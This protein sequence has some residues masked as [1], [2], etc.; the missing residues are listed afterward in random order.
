VEGIPFRLAE[1]FVAHGTYRAHKA[2][3]AS[4]EPADFSQTQVLA[5]G[6]LYFINVDPAL[7]AN[8]Q[9]SFQQSANGTVEQITMNTVPAAKDTLD[10]VTGAITG[11]AGLFDGGAAAA[12]ATADDFVMNDALLSALADSLSGNSTIAPATVLPACNTG[13]RINR[14]VR[15]RDN[16]VFE[17]NGS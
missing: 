9:F 10:S 12:P 3:G 1:V 8:T 5:T 15:M 13:G 4:C 16:R 11:V 14:Y 6:D 2:R 17:V 7:L